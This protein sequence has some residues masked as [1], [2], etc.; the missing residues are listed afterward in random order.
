MLH[1]YSQQRCIWC[2]ALSLVSVIQLAQ[3]ILLT[4]EQ[5]ILLPC[6]RTF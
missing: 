2:Q 6:L 4:T 5:T 3:L 1:I